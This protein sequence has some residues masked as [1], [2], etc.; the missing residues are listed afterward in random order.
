MKEERDLYYTLGLEP[1]ASSNEIKTA[2]RRL[3]KLYHPDRDHSLDAEVKY[4]EIREAYKA[5]LEWS[6]N[7]ESV[8]KN[9]SQMHTKRTADITT[10]N[11]YYNGNKIPI[12]W[13]FLRFLSS[14]IGIFF[15]YP[16][17]WVITSR[18]TFLIER[19][20]LS[21]VITVGVVFL[22]SIRIISKELIL[23]RS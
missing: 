23:R 11:D 16:P 6:N 17:L 19:I 15:F 13:I 4:R 7:S 2:F 12:M 14:L 20:L 8:H 18:E 3:T 22:V 9:N 10:K 21:F 1:G 5:L